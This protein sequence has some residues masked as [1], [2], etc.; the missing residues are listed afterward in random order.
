MR[1]AALSYGHGVDPARITGRV[2]GV[3]PHACVIR[4]DDGATLTLVPREAGSLP[5]GIVVDAPNGFSFAAIVNDVRADARAGILRFAGFELSVDLRHAKA[6]RSRLDAIGLD[7]TRVDSCAAW[8]GAAAVLAADGRAG[9]FA[10]Q[11]VPSI[12]ALPATTSAASTLIGL[13]QGSTPDGDDFLVGYLGALRAVARDG[14]RRALLAAL[15]QTIA[16]AA[17]RTVWISRTYLAAAGVGEVSERLTGVIAALASGS[18]AETGR[19]ARAVLAVGHSSGA[20]GLLGVLAGAV[21][22]DA[23][24]RAAG[25]LKAVVTPEPIPMVPA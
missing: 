13:G 3:F 21:A 24:E 20:C 8:D 7:L 15:G 10:H 22:W 6:W 16:D 17:H 25:L 18:S 5:G 14:G 19:A 12:L 4:C 23:P 1:L 2:A 9:I 11:A